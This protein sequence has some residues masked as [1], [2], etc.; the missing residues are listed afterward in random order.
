MAWDE[1]IN[2]MVRTL[3][4]DADST[5][6]DDDR[7]NQ[8]I[9]M[10]MQ[11]VQME[12][13]LSADYEVDVV[14]ETVTPDPT[15]GDDRDIDFMKLVSVKTACMIDQGSASDAASQAIRV[16][17]GA[18]EVD[19][20]DAFKAKFDLLKIGWCQVYA[21][22]KRQYSLGQRGARLG[23]AIMTPFRLF[24]GYGSSDM[25]YGGAGL[26]RPFNR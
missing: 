1:E 7:I 8:A 17:D 18:S 15:I 13:S 19:L 24:N 3:V 20:R 9:L 2:I 23:A 5:K 25:P 14:N 4:N 6:Y 10:A 16:K 26:L 12:I 22:L 11:L 21:D